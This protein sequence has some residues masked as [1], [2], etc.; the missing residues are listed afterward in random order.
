MG[1]GRLTKT[2]KDACRQFRDFTGAL[3]KFGV[4][5]DQVLMHP[6]LYML[7]EDQGTCKFTRQDLLSSML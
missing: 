3:N 7:K 5:F 4:R 6:V 1:K 2:Q